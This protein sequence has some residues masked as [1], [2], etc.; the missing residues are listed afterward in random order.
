M[1]DLGQT[2]AAA[3]AAH[4]AGR[5][6]EAEPLY[7]QVL[8]ATPDHH[9]ALDALGVLLMQTRRA[10]EA[11]PLFERACQLS[12]QHA[13][14]VNHLGAAYGAQGR[15]DEAVSALRRAVQ[16]S[17]QSSAA[18]YNLGTALRNA[19]RL[20]E[21]A[22]SFRHAVAAD[23]QGAEAHYNL[24]NTLRELKQPAE[25]EASYRDAIAA[26]P[27]YLKA[28]VNLG[29][30]LRDEK[31]Y[32]ESIE[33]LLS[34]TRHDSNYSPA[35][36]NL[37][38]VQRDAG[39]FAVAEES[40]RR[41]VA[42]APEQAEAHNNLGTALQALARLD[43]AGA[44]YERA[45]EL[46][47]TLADAHFSCATWRLR[48]GDLAGGFA[49][50]EWR[51][52]CKTFAEHG[53]TEP[54]WDGSPLAGRTILLWAEQGL[55]D[56]LQFVRYAKNVRQTAD[57]VILI[58]QPPLVKIFVGVAG[59]DQVVPMGQQPPR[60]D[61]H[62]P[63]LS[64][65]H[66]LKLR[67]HEY[68]ARPYLRADAALNEKWRT[69]LA[70]LSGLRVG[71]CWRGNPEHLFNA[72]RS[73]ALASL[74]PLAQVK[75]VQFVSL[76]KGA[77]DELASAGFEVL[78]L[79][80]DLD[81]TAGPFMDSAAVIEQLDLVVSA[82]TAVAHLAG[83]LGARVWLP[84]SAHADWRWMLDRRDTPW[85]PTMR[86]F[87]QKTL[88]DWSMVFEEMAAELKAFGAARH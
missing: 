81:A 14:Y 11:T 20:Q 68:F 40:L 67:E 85:Y 35:W 63:L 13:E 47:P 50:Y 33:V 8:A 77:D 52:Q 22:V 42:L 32:D 28:L 78:N 19:D 58:C 37:G 6:A 16:L 1:T 57:R 88:D 80:A 76:Q 66:L 10:A 65:P 23:P 49:E 55:G 73:F 18:H 9:G 79:G 43:E 4:Q 75:G 45:I 26:R 83:G 82:D 31:R 25:A 59:I 54:A 84:L 64:L 36:L 74:A 44:C 86:L 7:R 51:W 5:L 3:L 70:E 30:L 56:T 29:N 21:A 87:R 41:A 12:P 24:G 17:P 72:Q 69:R 48:Q 53:F 2:L 62:A 39:Q 34:A 38:I 61:V 71:I 46:D 15:H 60:F 27:G